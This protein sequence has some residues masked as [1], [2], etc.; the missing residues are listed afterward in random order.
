M[1]K[2]TKRTPSQVIRAIQNSRGIKTVAAR[3]LKVDRKTLDGYLERWPKVKQ[4]YM[5]EVETLLDD[6]ENVLFD[7]ALVEQS[8][9]SLHFLLERKGKKR[10]YSR[11]AELSVDDLDVDVVFQIGSSSGESS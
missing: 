5:D 7:K 3:R 2:K 6:A 1:T 9:S 4:A 8:E 10:G 11:R